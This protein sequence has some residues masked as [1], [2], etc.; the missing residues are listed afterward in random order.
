MAIEISPQWTS[1]NTRG[2]IL[3][4]CQNNGEDGVPD[5]FVS[6]VGIADGFQRPRF[7]QQLADS[8]VQPETMAVFLRPSA[9]QAIFLKEMEVLDPDTWQG[10]HFEWFSGSW[11]LLFPKQCGYT[12][13]LR[14]S[15][16]RL[17]PGVHSR[18]YPGRFASFPVNFRIKWLLWH[19]HVHF[20]CADPHETG[21]RLGRLAVPVNFRMKW[22]LWH[23]HVHFDCA[24]SHKTRN[25][26]QN[27]C[28]ETS[29]RELVQRSCQETS[30]GDLVQRHCIEICWDL[31]KRSRYINLAKR[32]LIE[33]L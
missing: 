13:A 17:R 16:G 5:F 10:G 26:I 9:N 19:V 18:W 27:S 8:F 7:W 2:H 33:S 4:H 20:D 12:A 15:Y 32:A 11:V 25:L 1:Q 23:V 29:F 28:Q 30:Y 24:G 22:L 14:G 31:A 21:A 6:T 3:P